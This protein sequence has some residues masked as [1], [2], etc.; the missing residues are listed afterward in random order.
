[1]KMW[2]RPDLADEFV[3]E[4][5]S[6]LNERPHE[7]EE[8]S[9][10]ITTLV[11][12]LRKAKLHRL[13]VPDEM[14]SEGKITV[15]RGTAY[16]AMLPKYAESEVNRLAEWYPEIT[17]PDDI[18]DHTVEGK[19][20]GYR[21]KVAT[22]EIT[23]YVDWEEYGVVEGDGRLVHRVVNELKT[24]MAGTKNG[25]SPHYVEQLAGEAWMAGTNWGRLLV[26]HLP[27]PPTLKVYEYWFSDDELEQ[28]GR[29]LERRLGVLRADGVPSVDE[30]AD[31]ECRYCGYYQKNADGDPETVKATGKCPGSKG[32]AQAWFSTGTLANFLTPKIEG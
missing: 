18:G 30:H 25:P 22:G 28:W 21:K 3:D 7:P 27:F 2:E 4:V 14:T 1:M 19:E 8:W 31:W 23:C 11:G 5:Y 10:G 16:H 20:V 12:C 13:G 24:T 9:A 17:L 26:F 6:R 29:E 32:R 15:M